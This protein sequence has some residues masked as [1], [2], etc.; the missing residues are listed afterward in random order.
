MASEII[1]YCKSCIVEHWKELETEL[2]GLHARSR[3]KFGL[4]PKIPR[5]GIP[6]AL[7]ANGCRIPNGRLGYCGL[8]KN[9]N[10]KLLHLAGIPE[11]GLLKYYYDPLPTNCV[12]SWCCAERDTR[13]KSN[14]AI[15]YGACSMNCLFCQNWHFRFLTKEMTSFYSSKAV[16]E[17]VT[18]D[19]A[20]ICFF[21]GD[22]AP[23]LLHAIDVA[24]LVMESKKPVRICLETNGLENSAML[25]RLANY[26]IES[27]G[28]IKIDLKF[29]SPELSMAISGV[30]N[31]RSYENFAMLASMLEEARHDCFLVASTLLIPFYVD[32]DEVFKIAKFIAELNE[33]LPYSLLAFYPAFLLRD[34][35]TTSREQAL[36]CLRAAKLAGLKRIRIGNV[37]LLS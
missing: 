6:C 20:C 28:T 13:G 25:K 10:G 31:E 27:G 21:G 15:F 11:K 2:L 1:G 29:F 24:K 32:E 36:R 33:D 37:H 4:P 23:Q 16:Y 35:P 12:A 8:R 3:K 7:C 26:V 19:V 5:K 34:L 30:S 22:P 17:K 14:L 9:E 18:D